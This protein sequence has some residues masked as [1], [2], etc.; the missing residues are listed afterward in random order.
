ML[1][2]IISLLPRYQLLVVLLFEIDNRE[3]RG[4]R[5]QSLTFVAEARTDIHIVHMYVPD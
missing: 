4:G 5:L 2:I 1:T 3:V